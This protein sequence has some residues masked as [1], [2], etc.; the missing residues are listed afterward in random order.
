MGRVVTVYVQT[1]ATGHSV[2]LDPV[3]T[4]IFITFF[5]GTITQK[6]LLFHGEQ[7]SVIA[8][9]CYRHALRLDLSGQQQGQGGQG[10]GRKCCLIP[11][12]GP[13]PPAFA[14]P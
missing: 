8:L 12:L 6:Y 7:A 11:A 9:F 14:P 13:T 10:G 2:D 1:L 5:H 3:V 4:E